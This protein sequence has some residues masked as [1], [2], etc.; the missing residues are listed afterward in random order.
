MRYIFQNIRITARKSPAVFIMY[1]LSCM[2]SV[3]VVMFSH[4]VYQNYQTKATELEQGKNVGPSGNMIM[5]YT[6]ICFGNI[7]A[8]HID[9]PGTDMNGQVYEPY[10]YYEADGTTTVGD[11]RKVLSMLDERTKTEFGGFFVWGDIDDTF[12]EYP[13][14]DFD[15]GEYYKYFL[16]DDWFYQQHEDEDLSKVKEKPPVFM[17]MLNIRIEYRKEL[18]IFSFNE[19]AA[20]N[21]GDAVSGEKISDEHELNGDNVMVLSDESWNSDII[22]K[23]VR[24]L[25][26]DY[27]VIGLVGSM[28]DTLYVPFSSI[29][30][31]VIIKEV[32]IMPNKPISTYAYRHM[33]QAFEEVYGDYV[34]F[35]EMYT[36]DTE[37]KTFYVSIMMISVVLSVLA[38][39][40]LAILY[41][42]IIF[43]RRKTMS[44]MRLC[45]C[46][47]G[48]IRLM[49]LLEIIGS[50][51]LI[52]AVCAYAYH[53][54]ILGKLTYFL[55]R[56]DEVYSLNTYLY[57]YG[58][59]IGVLFVV[60]NIMISTQLDKQPV[61][62]FRR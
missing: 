14:Y 51:S 50:A 29:P 9:D 61:N 4:G 60:I 11:F 23:T 31:D 28:G 41:R 20:R 21:V 13:D 44:V 12:R 53:K 34:N 16:D 35:P 24:F 7:T 56:I 25:G 22:G 26:K 52:F 19:F 58:V 45:G 10:K 62:M 27:K 43:T 3:V 59:F 36:V 1:V 6:P 38:A 8:E 48:K 2:V 15:C 40:I 39:I 37:E 55:D 46:T 47:R 5:A 49:Y 42:Y 17:P 57:I 30:D 32:N 18:G 33:K 54:L